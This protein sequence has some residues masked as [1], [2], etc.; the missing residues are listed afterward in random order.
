MGLMYSWASPDYLF[1]KMTLPQVLLFFDRGREAEEK[2]TLNN[3]V[4]FWGVLGQAL[5]GEDTENIK[6]KAIQG[7]QKFKESHP[8]GTQDEK[9]AWSVSR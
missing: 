4:T 2:K 8:D 3:A 1:D 5:Q 7:I 9:G 6:E